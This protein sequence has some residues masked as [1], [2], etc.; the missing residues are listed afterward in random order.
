MQAGRISPVV[1][2]G[3]A[4]ESSGRVA[5]ARVPHLTRTRATSA[6]K[7]G[8]GFSSVPTVVEVVA[9]VEEVVVVEEVEAAVVVVVEEEEE[10][11]VVVEHL[12]EVRWA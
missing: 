10:E 5:R 3:Q 12:L 2:F 4:L 9:E 11:V 6:S 7:R 8:T 1:Q